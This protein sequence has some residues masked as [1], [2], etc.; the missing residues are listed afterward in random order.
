MADPAARLGTTDVLVHEF[1][2]EIDWAVAV[3]RGLAPPLRPALSGPCDTHLFA[4]YEE[5]VELEEPK[6]FALFLRTGRDV[7]AEW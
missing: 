4:T 2:A 7:F 5:S 6:Q 1:F 3:R